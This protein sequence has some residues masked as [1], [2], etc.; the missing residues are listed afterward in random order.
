MNENQENTNKT[1]D[2]NSLFNWYE[3]T[4]ASRIQN[5]FD[6]FF[7]N[8]FQLKLVSLSKNLNVLF[9][10]DNY[11]VTKV[12]ID[13]NYDIFFR[14]SSGAVKVILDDVLGSSK[15]FDISAISD[16]EAKLISTF[17]DFT[18][19]KVI[20]LLEQPEKGAK[21]KNFDIINLTFF[22][23]GS[24]ENCGKFILALPK[25]L[26]L[27]QAPQNEEYDITKFNLSE[28]NSKISIGN[29]IFRLK[30]L[31]SLE[32]DDIVVLDNSNIE[33]MHITYKD[34]EKDFQ[35]MPREEIRISGSDFTGEDMS[36]SN[37]LPKNLWDSIQVEMGA[38]LESVRVTLGELRAI[39]KGQVMDLHS[40]YDSKVS[41]IVENQVV[42]KGDLVIVNDRYGV[43]IS[44]VYEAI[45][46]GEYIAPAPRQI[47]ADNRQMEQSDFDQ[48][49]PQMEQS[50]EY[51][52]E[53]PQEGSE[54][55]FDYSDFNLDDQDI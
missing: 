26:V 11:F 40:I 52:G 44:D 9:Q 43:K 16:L 55:D 21:R 6:E 35:V 20:D 22:I 12:R 31:K 18:Y 1:E 45:S 25:D 47:Q 13:K 30:E 49:A 36:E 53:V 2:L 50:Q 14:C 15:S 19:N 24:S 48:Q 54:E 42:A 32:V 38:E 41:L 51:Q 37:E 17:N 7:G 8:K 27:P 23:K 29:T 5:A 46:Q 10:G 3:N 39:A 33:S 34:Y 28:L 4:Y